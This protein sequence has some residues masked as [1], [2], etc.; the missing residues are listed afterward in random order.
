METLFLLSRTQLR[1][2]DRNVSSSLDD[3][4]VQ[5]RDIANVTI[6]PKFLDPL[7]YFDVAIWEMDRPVTFTTF[8]R[9]IC[10]PRHASFDVDLHVGQH[11]TLTGW[12]QLQKNSI[13]IDGMLK[14]VPIK[15]FPQM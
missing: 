5:I 1:L 4:H 8:V 2:G 11:V 10:L 13:G 6:H 14:Q 15:I 9:P 7:S 12:G 3:E